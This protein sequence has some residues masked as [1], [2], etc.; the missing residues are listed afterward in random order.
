MLSM[1]PQQQEQRIVELT[2]A[3]NI[4]SGQLAALMAY[5]LAVTPALDPAQ[6][7][8]VQGIAQ[9]LAPSPVGVIP[10]TPPKLAASQ[11]IEQMTSLAA[12]Q[13]NQPQP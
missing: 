13:K 10:K 12:Q 7:G 5:V 9:N 6:K 8:R 3:V 1:S 2:E 4:L 11:G